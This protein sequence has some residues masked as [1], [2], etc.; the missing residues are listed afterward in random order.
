ML[1]CCSPID[2]LN[3][4]LDW[5]SPN[6]DCSTGRQRLKVSVQSYKTA[7]SCSSIARRYGLKLLDSLQLDHRLVVPLQGIS[8]ALL[9]FLVE[10]DSGELV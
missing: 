6:S 4:L 7:H 10:S 2:S 3:K 5:A 9:E 1:V 8:I